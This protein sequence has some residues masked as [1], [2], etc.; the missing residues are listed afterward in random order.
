MR[1]KIETRAYGMDVNNAILERPLTI[2]INQCKS[3]ILE[4]KSNIIINE[5]NN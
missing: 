3:Q 5:E 2:S 1:G 4:L